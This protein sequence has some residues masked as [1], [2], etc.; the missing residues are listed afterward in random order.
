MDAIIIVCWLIY[1]I[2]ALLIA[3][4]MIMGYQSLS[5]KQKILGFILT[6]PFGLL[7]RLFWIGWNKIG[8]QSE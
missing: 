2:C 7:I 8:N 3:M 6:F 4:E 5:T 1:F